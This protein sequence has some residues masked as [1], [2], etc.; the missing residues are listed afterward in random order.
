MAEPSAWERISE[1][2]AENLIS[3][4]HGTVELGI[5]FLVNLPYLAVWGAV[6]TAVI[7]AV[8]RHHRKRKKRLEEQLKKAAPTEIPVE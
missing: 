5:W 3:I 8:R 4:G 1:G 2:F 7:F 6:L